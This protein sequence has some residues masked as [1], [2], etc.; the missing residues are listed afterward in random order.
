MEI[1]FNQFNGV[2]VLQNGIIFPVQLRCD[3]IGIKSFPEYQYLLEKLAIV[4]KYHTNAIWRYDKSD[5]LDIFKMASI[6]V[7]ILIVRTLE[8]WMVNSLRPLMVMAARDFYATNR[9]IT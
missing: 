8:L 7:C 1:N 3:T 2:T 6:F 4:Q 9:N 5:I